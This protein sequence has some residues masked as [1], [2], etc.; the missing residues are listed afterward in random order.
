[1]RH[2]KVDGMVR[3]TAELATKDYLDSEIEVLQL[4]DRKRD[5]G[6]PKAGLALRQERLKLHMAVAQ[7]DPGHRLEVQAADRRPPPPLRGQQEAPRK[8]AQRK[9]AGQLQAAVE[10]EDCLQSCV[11]EPLRA[12][13]RDRSPP[14][15]AVQASQDPRGTQKTLPADPPRRAARTRKPLPR[16]PGQT[17]PGKRR[18]AV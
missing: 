5:K 18:R 17:Q 15:G 12:Q 4:V 7:A 8:R 14:A 13:V 16:G 1:M 3:R 11:A 9:V 10:R 6:L 2:F